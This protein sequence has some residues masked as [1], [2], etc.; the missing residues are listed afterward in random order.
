MSAPPHLCPDKSQAH[1]ARLCSTEAR[2][3]V[4]MAAILAS[5]MGF[6]DGSVVSVAMPAIRADLDASLTQVLWI[7]NAYLLTL[8]ALLLVGGALADRF[9]VSRVFTLS[10]AG[11]VITSIACSIAPTADSLI[12]ARA[13][14]GV[15][16]AVMVPGSLAIIA[17]AYPADARGRAIG[18]WAAASALTTA[19]GPVL[20]GALLDVA[21]AS[22]WRMIFALNL[23]LGAIAVWLLLTRT[24]PVGGESSTRLDVPG[25]VLATLGLG[26][27][28]YGLSGAEHGSAIDRAMLVWS[29]AGLGVFAGFLLVEARSPH[30]M[31]PLRLFWSRA[32]SAANLITFAL[33]FAL[34]AVL[35]YL[36]MTV[37]SGWGLSAF[38]ASLAFVPMTVFIAILSPLSGKW[39]EAHG[40]HKFI[41]T[42]AAIVAV[43]FA[44]LGLSAPSQAFWAATVPLCALMGFGLALAVAPLSSVVM[45]SV[46]EDATGA[47]SGINNAVSRVAGLCAVASMG[48]LAAATYAACGGTASFGAAADGAHHLSALNAGFTAVSLASAVLAALAAAWAVFRLRTP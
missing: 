36:P 27:L 14:Q 25:A 26:L 28:A 11:F 16:A 18:T 45:A 8:S 22:A 47:A 35:F 17:Q 33:Y 15:T 10:I 13:L 32:F 21:G 40:A 39:A 24:T 1:N 30:P 41:G 19:V 48:T 12:V 43:A 42:G 46:P 20:G 3:F 2:K 34:S 23:P 5:A 29:G 4:L 6:I 31:M 38:E 7:S 37:I 9:G 44:G